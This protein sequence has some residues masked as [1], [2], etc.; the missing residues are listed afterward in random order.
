MI[1]LDA[2]TTMHEPLLPCAEDHKTRDIL[3]VPWSSGDYSYA[4]TRMYCVRVPR[5]D[6]IWCRVHDDV[7][8]VIEG[9][10][11]SG[12]DSLGWSDLPDLPYVGSGQCPTCG[13]IGDMGDRQFVEI[14]GVYF[15]AE[16]LAK[17]VHLKNVQI[18]VVGKGLPAFLRF[19]GGLGLVMPVDR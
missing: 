11:Y 8:V 5:Q 2:F 4:A 19:D 12:D 18:S 6:A 16:L 9:Y 1:N 14:F 10:V 3:S 17:F 7:R 15:D 13:A